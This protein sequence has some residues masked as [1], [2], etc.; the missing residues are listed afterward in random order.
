MPKLDA[1][2][3]IYG[4]IL[5][6]QGPNF[7]SKYPTRFYHPDCIIIIPVKFIYPS[8]PQYS[9]G[10]FNI[11]V[12]RRRWVGGQSNVYATSVKTLFC[13]VHLFTRGR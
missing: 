8:I 5:G 6:A 3:M 13:L 4:Q 11:Y 12:N 2:A 7:H 9:I 10:S 1:Q